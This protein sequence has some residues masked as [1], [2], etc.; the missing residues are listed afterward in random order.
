MARICGSAGVGIVQQRWRARPGLPRHG[1]GGGAAR[2]PPG[3]R[4]CSPSGGSFGSGVV[5]QLVETDRQ[6]GESSSSVGAADQRQPH[7]DL[8]GQRLP[9]A[10][11][12]RRVEQNLEPGW[13]T[14]DPPTSRS[15]RH[16][17]CEPGF[18]AGSQLSSTWR[19]SRASPTASRT[20]SR[21]PSAKAR[22][23]MAIRLACASA[24]IR[25]SGSSSSIVALAATWM[26]L[27][28]VAARARSWKAARM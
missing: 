24:G 27:F 22:N 19:R 11:Y 12:D 16:R 6:A 7:G 10:H 5:A 2:L 15:S 25:P 14:A 18:A 9:L 1:R 26:M 3:G 23:A 28:R 20:M 21:A 4:P 8:R 13:P 17:P